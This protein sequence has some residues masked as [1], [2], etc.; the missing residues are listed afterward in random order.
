M[1]KLSSGFTLIELL[2]VI[3]V[4]GIL[5]V[6]V[7]SAIN[8]IE[9]INRSRDTGSRS[10]AEQLIGAVD[11]FYATNGYYPW[12]T[13]AA[14]TAHL[15]QAWLQVTTSWADVTPLGV[16]AKLSQSGTEELKSSFTNRI[17]TTTYNPLFVYNSGTV[18]SSTYVCFLAK[19]GAFQTESGTRCGGTLPSDFP[20][21][22]C[23]TG[24]TTAKTCYSC[25]P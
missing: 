8:P 15:A 1:K 7:L 13:G 20:A 14:D 16:L 12:Q 19:S 2:I 21:G 5:A 6:A 11:R 18:G 4:L 25:L 22:A 24:C 9:Q 3:A 10:D 17:T 23:P